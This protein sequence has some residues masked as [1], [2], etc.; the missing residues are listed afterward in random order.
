MPFTTAN[1][2]PTQARTAPAS[3]RRVAVLPAI[4]VLEVHGNIDGTVAKQLIY[5]LLDLARSGAT[6]V[7]VDLSAVTAS[8]FSLLAALARA[9]TAVRA[10]AG[11]LY[12][13]AASDA[14]LEQLRNSGLDRI[15]AVF[16]TRDY[17]DQVDQR[18]HGVTNVRVNRRN[19]VIDLRDAVQQ[20]HRHT[21]ITPTSL[22]R[23][24]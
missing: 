4:G 3:V 12:L 7:A 14:M 1:D 15:A 23:A 13:M 19:R 20:R 8:D 22:A 6:S 24:T 2:F 5:D 21:R 16:L 10:R 11:H 17:R 9:H 18:A